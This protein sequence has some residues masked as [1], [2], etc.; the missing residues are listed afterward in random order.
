[1]KSFHFETS[2]DKWE[3]IK[4]CWNTIQSDIKSNHNDKNKKT[5]SNVLSTCVDTLNEELFDQNTGNNDN[6]QK[7][8]DISIETMNDLLLEIDSETTSNKTVQ[9][10][11][12]YPSKIVE[13]IRLPV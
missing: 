12:L 5:D 3:R 11:S 6:T 1:M 4:K 9:L 13:F 10:S 2:L 8:N 7:N